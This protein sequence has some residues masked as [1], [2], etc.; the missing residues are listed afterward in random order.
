M[1]QEKRNEYILKMVEVFKSMEKHS[2]LNHETIY[3][4]CLRYEN[5]SVFFKATS[6]EDYTRRIESKMKKVSSETPTPALKASASA[7]SAPSAKPAQP[8]A[9]SSASSSTPSTTLDWKLDSQKLN[10]F[11]KTGLFKREANARQHQRVFSD[12][13]Q[14]W[15]NSVLVHTSKYATKSARPLTPAEIRG[16]ARIIPH[17]VVS[18]QLPARPVILLEVKTTNCG[19]EQCMLFV[20]MYSDGKSSA[21]NKPIAFDLDSNTNFERSVSVISKLSIL[22]VSHVLGVHPHVASMLHGLGESFEDLNTHTFERSKLQIPT[23]YDS[24]SLLILPRVDSAIEAEFMQI[25]ANKQSEIATD[26]QL[27]LK[28]A[29][30][31]KSFRSCIEETQRANLFASIQNYTQSSISLTQNSINLGMSIVDAIVKGKELKKAQML[32]HQPS[33]SHSTKKKYVS[34][35]SDC[36]DEIPPPAMLVKKKQRAPPETGEARRSNATV[37]SAKRK[38][39]DTVYSDHE[40]HSEGDSDSNA[41]DLGDADKRVVARRRRDEESDDM[42]SSSDAT[43]STTKA[44]PGGNGTIDHSISNVKKQIDND[45]S[46]ES[47]TSSEDEEELSEDDDEEDGDGGGDGS[48][49]DEDEM[50]VEDEQ[51]TNEVVSTEEP[52]EHK[53]SHT[54]QVYNARPLQK[55]KKTTAHT[56]PSSSSAPPAPSS[57]PPPAPSSAPP[58][59][60]A[61]ERR[62]KEA[63]LV[64]SKNT[65]LTFEKCMNEVERAGYRLQLREVRDWI[66]K[67]SKIKMEGCPEG[68]PEGFQDDEWAKLRGANG[69]W[70]NRDLLPERYSGTDPPAEHPKSSHLTKIFDGFGVQKATL[71]SERVKLALGKAERYSTFVKSINASHVHLAGLSEAATDEKKTLAVRALY[72]SLR[73]TTSIVSGLVG[74]IEEMKEATKNP[75]TPQPPVSIKLLSIDT[76]QPIKSTASIEELIEANSTA[77]IEMS[78]AIAQMQKTLQ[79]AAAEFDSIVKVVG[80]QNKELTRTIDHLRVSKT[81]EGEERE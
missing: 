37:P 63:I 39:D 23:S 43:I 51:L 66:V 28:F 26:S 5:D 61:H 59:P 17:I 20:C 68:C 72:S 74:V 15:A 55:K 49:D 65:H 47:N 2:H 71:S 10:A 64:A 35:D 48:D 81:G 13:I 16:S 78:P 9:A 11:R 8:A 14:S 53:K 60:D 54:P 58:I 22:H 36:E 25:F 62:V 75:P 33:Q 40:S 19:K 18:K 4:L 67:Q 7:P 70:Q 21:S 57:A 52:T 1:G 29:T 42:L 77:I 56:E 76:S 45:N 44:D 80:V 79:R 3:Q 73:Q 30:Q 50:E 31:I 6:F 46:D 12:Q 41:S 24:V 34:K 27:D 38:I 32:A 69:V